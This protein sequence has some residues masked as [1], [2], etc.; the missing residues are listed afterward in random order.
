MKAFLTEI[1]EKRNG[2]EIGEPWKFSD[3][4]LLVVVPITRNNSPE[5]MYTTMYEV[6]KDL[7]MKD[8]GHID[9]VQLQNKSGKPIFVR[10]GTIF[11]GKTQ[12]RAAQHS[13]VYKEDAK[14][15][16]DV[17][18]VQ[19]THGISGG[20]EMKFGSI[21]PMSV[22]QNLMGRTQSDVWN[23][24]RTYT[25][26]KAFT[27]DGSPSGRSGPSGCTGSTG[28]TRTSSCRAQSASN[29]RK[30]RRASISDE[31]ATGLSYTSSN[32]N[33]VYGA[34]NNDC[35]LGAVYTCSSF[36]SE[37]ERGTGTDDLLG[38]LKNKN[39]D[40]LDEMMQK[41]PLFEDQTGAIIFDPLGII[42]LETFDSPKSW[43]AIK[44][45]VIEKYGDKVSDKQA[46]HLFELNKDMI[47][48]MLKKFIAGLDKFEEKTVRQ[49]D[50]SETRAVKGDKIVGEYT[51]IKGRIIHCLLLKE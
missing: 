45:E 28:P 12:N 5:R 35:F 9:K 17:R 1:V 50:F 27:Y 29:G 19:Q 31:F 23:S 8:T 34:S 18:C 41:V 43:E 21:A 44:A 7:G 47:L 46:E 2:F 14:V 13:G 48:P 42:A 32:D 22:T 24:V 33:P 51:L 6:L 36:D 40:A 16:I 10:A 38:Y 25:S 37:P 3:S 49:D 26:G 39:K 11:E 4:A 20:V 15:D 30:S